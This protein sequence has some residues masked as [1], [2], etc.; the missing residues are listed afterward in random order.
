MKT[1]ICPTGEAIVSQR[2]YLTA[3]A[4]KGTARALAPKNMT[5]VT[6]G[7]IACV[8]LRGSENAEVVRL[9]V[10]I[11]GVVTATLRQDHV[12]DEPLS[13]LEYDSRRLY[14]CAT[15][16]GTYALVETLPI[17]VDDPQGTR[18]EYAGTLGW[19]K[20]TY[21][22]SVAGDETDIA[23]STAVE[24]DQSGR[25]ATVAGIRKRA[26]M[27]KNNYLQDDTFATA[28]TRAESEVNSS[29]VVR[30]VLPLAEVPAIV[31][32]I[33]EMLAA[34]SVMCDEYGAEDGSRQVKMLGT[35]RGMLKD[36]REG[37]LRLVGL[38][39]TEPQAAS[40][41]RPVFYPT[42]VSAVDEENPTA[43]RMPRNKQY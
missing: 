14:A 29:V 18:F 8:G 7:A 5:G 28:R 26:G 23:D 37:T 1:I 2:T 11:S 32:D 30:Y 4:A 24:G 15:A 38:D 40:G 39:G 3:D 9:A 10:S 42:A 20:A 21:F 6:D 22:D 41:C 25:Y 13:V 35:A 43:A 33:T 17:A 12:A 36:I 34:G 31:G 16:A 27:T 19:F